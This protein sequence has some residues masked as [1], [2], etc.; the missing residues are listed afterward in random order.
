MAEKVREAEAHSPKRLAAGPTTSSN[1]WTLG[2]DVAVRRVAAVQQ[3]KLTAVAASKAGE[4]NG[5]T[6]RSIDAHHA[7]HKR[8]STRNLEPGGGLQ[9]GDGGDCVIGNEE[10]EE[11]VSAKGGKTHCG[12][13]HEARNLL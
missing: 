10:L 5:Q 3:T 8:D 13:P 1:Q 4:K 11:Q 6:G 9:S 2:C 7:G 12:R